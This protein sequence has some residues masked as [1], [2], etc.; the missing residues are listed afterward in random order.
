[1]MYCKIC[2]KQFGEDLV[3]LWTVVGSLR[4]DGSQ[5]Y[6]TGRFGQVHDLRKVKAGEKVDETPASDFSDLMAE[7][8]Q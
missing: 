5:L 4:S 1:M 6:S 8:L 7:V 3:N 2:E